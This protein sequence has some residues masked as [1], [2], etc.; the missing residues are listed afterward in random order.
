MFI[1]YILIIYI[2]NNILFI[3]IYLQLYISNNLLY[4]L[5]YFFFCNFI[6]FFLKTT[7]NISI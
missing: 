5:Y 1:K 3:F 7:Y 2:N 6:Y 4:I